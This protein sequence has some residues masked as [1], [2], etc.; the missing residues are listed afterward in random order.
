[1]IQQAMTAAFQ[2][3]RI[4]TLPSRV[5]ALPLPTIVEEHLPFTVRLVRDEED[6]NKAVH[7]RHAA[8]ARHM[9][10]VAETLKTPEKIDV[11]D[12]VVVLLAESKLD[13]SPLG[14]VRIQ[15]NRYRP[16]SL[17]KSVELPAWLK[18]QSLAQVSRFG[19]INGTIGRL[20]K[21]I[22]VKGCLQYSEHEGIDWNVIAARSP[23]DRTYKQLTYQDIFPDAGL[24]P[25]A[26]MDNVPHRIMGFEVETCKERLTQLN[27][28][29]LAF[30]CHT[31]HPDLDV[32]S[33]SAGALTQKL[34]KM[35][36]DSI[37]SFIN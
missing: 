23:L 30:F 1:M 27:H 37:T 33:T 21:M 17:E 9:P 18:G 6:L 14:S 22:L 28:P 20:V 12:G 24:I 34:R 3:H 4:E 15:T 36:N 19:V 5:D 2:P 29:L 11:E 10:T 16:L 7:I 26:H 31:Y 8:Y 35:N 13:G 25:L 32:G